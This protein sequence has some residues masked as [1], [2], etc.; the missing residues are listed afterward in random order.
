ML[1]LFLIACCIFIAMALLTGVVLY[2]IL[3][4]RT[5]VQERLG[6]IADEKT[7][8]A[9]LV[10]EVP[11]WQE[12]LGRVGESLPIKPK[13][14]SQYTKTLQAAGLKKEILPLFLGSKILLAAVLPCLYAI[15]YALPKGDLLKPTS[16]LYMAALA[17][18]GFLAPSFWLTH[19][20]EKRKIEIFHTLPDV[21]DLLTICVEAGLGLDG[22]LVKTCDSPQFKGNPLADEIKVASMETRAGKPRTA[23]LKDMGERTMVDDVKQFVTML[24]QTE[25]FGTSLGV[26]LRVHSDSLRTKRR[27]IAEE[28]A[29]KTAIK[30]LFPL[31]FLIFPALMVVIL[32]PAF[33]KFQEVFK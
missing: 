1:S 32:G 22:A 27:Q 21:L 23:A 7:K 3:T 4:R 24:I 5:P 10:A 16:I 30:M 29:A 19:K 20:V 9:S 11:Q 31:A 17:I 12:T 13:E 14:R 28:A 25:R 26:A 15:F 8:A 2:P 18:V 33:F 6:K